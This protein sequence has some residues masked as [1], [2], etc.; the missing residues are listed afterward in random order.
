[1]LSNRIMIGLWMTMVLD[2]IFAFY[3]TSV[4]TLAL[5][6]LIN[7]ENQARIL[8]GSEEICH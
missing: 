2:P 7:E 3:S 1:M 8:P 5:K 4:G 6:C